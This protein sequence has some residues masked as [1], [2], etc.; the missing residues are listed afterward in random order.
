MYDEEATLLTLFCR[1][2][3]EDTGREALRVKR[4][5][6]FHTLTWSQIADDVRRSAAA[7][8]R[9]GV[10]PGDRVVQISENRYEWI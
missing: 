5:G 3:A 2:V 6:E 8:V 10:A 7:L 4:K 9:L 1:R